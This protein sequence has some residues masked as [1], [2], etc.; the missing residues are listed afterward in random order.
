MLF[1][2]QAE[3]GS[4]R[5]TKEE[6]LN[7]GR[8]V[9]A[10]RLRKALS[11]ISL[12][13]ASQTTLPPSARR[14]AWS[15]SSLVSPQ[16]SPCFL[17]SSTSLRRNIPVTLSMA[18]SCRITTLLF[19]FR[20]ITTCEYSFTSLYIALFRKLWRVCFLRASAAV[21]GGVL[22]ILKILYQKMLHCVSVNLPT[23]NKVYF[24]SYPLTVDLFI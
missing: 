22:A 3:W 23:Q 11:Y 1:F 17:S 12:S 13:E 18:I 6:L 20:E 4:V 2:P 10:N 9:K 7:C 24:G 8:I 5:L 14:I 15:I 21:W 19:L 16:L